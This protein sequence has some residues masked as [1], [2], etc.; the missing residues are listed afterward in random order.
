MVRFDN[1]VYRGQEVLRLDALQVKDEELHTRLLDACEA[2][3]KR[4]YC[5]M[6]YLGQRQDDGKYEPDPAKWS[7]QGRKSQT[8]IWLEFRHVYL[9]D[10]DRPHRVCV[11]ACNWVA[12]ERAPLN[13]LKP[14]GV[15]S[16]RFTL[17]FMDAFGRAR[18]GAAYSGVC[19]ENPERPELHKKLPSDGV[20]IQNERVYWDLACGKS[21]C[22]SLVELKHASEEDLAADGEDAYRAVGGVL[23]YYIA[24][25]PCHEGRRPHLR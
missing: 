15:V 7:V 21:V 4:T 18:C 17:E 14:G 9:A 5:P 12:R 10:S 23:G 20:D 25:T 1:A 11:L 13:P 3:A 24:G 8:R 22:M 2:E 19:Y 6:R 16:Y